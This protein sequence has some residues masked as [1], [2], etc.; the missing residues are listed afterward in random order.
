MRSGTGGVS[1][2]EVSVRPVAGGAERA[3]WDRLMDA[4]HYLGFRCL[5]GGGVRHVAVAADGRWLALV[6]WQ[7]GAF[8]ARRGT[9]GSA[10]RR[11][12]SSVVCGWWRTTRGS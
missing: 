12:S 3:E 2:S 7:C 11:S 10:G 6:G 5:F 8:K 1:L 4:H 9:P